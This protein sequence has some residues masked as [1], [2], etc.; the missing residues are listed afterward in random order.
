MNFYELNGLYSGIGYDVMS[1][2]ALEKTNLETLKA[3]LKDKVSMVSGHSGVGKS[4]LVNALSPGLD[5]KT[6][7]VVS[8]VT[9]QNIG[10]ADDIEFD[11]KTAVIH[12]IVIFGRPKFFG[13]FGRE[14]DLKISWKD[15]VTIGK[16]VVLINAPEIYGGGK[17]GKTNVTFD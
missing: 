8:I 15:I 2:S 11:E 17:N 4:T 7:D 1:V 16:D 12:N 10:R 6:K 3:Q 5:L 9:G 14:K 13:I